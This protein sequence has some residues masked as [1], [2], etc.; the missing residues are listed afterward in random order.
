M[1][2]PAPSIINRTKNWIKLLNRRSRSGTIHPDEKTSGGALTY[3]TSLSEIC[4]CAIPEFFSNARDFTISDAQFVNELKI[5]YINNVVSSRQ[6][7][8]CSF[9]SRSCQ[10]SAD[11]SWQ[12][13]NY[14]SRIH[15][16]MRPKTLAL[17]IHHQGATL[18]RD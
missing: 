7:G 17:G 8:S 1:S 13:S 2:R 18:K 9:T 15:A 14:W 11:S 12:P 16:S 10:A 5:N 3:L 4:S 6:A